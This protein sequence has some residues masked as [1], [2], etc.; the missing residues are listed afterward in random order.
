MNKLIILTYLM[1][2]GGVA[3]C[4]SSQVLM[5]K[6]RLLCLSLDQSVLKE[7]FDLCDFSCDNINVFDFEN[8][9]PEFGCKQSVCGKKVT[10]YNTSSIDH[11]APN[12]IVVYKLTLNKKEGVISLF[13]PYSGASITLTVKLNLA[14]ELEITSVEVGAF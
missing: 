9:V 13:R 4:Q 5:L 10:V 7:E 8:I 6:Q 2:I 3:S 14:G 1:F 12:S 11:P